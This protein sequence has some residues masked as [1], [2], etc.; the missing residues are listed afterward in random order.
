MHPVT[1]QRGDATLL[2]HMLCL[3]NSDM[4]FPYGH[5]KQAVCVL[6]LSA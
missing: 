6:G 1:L 2:N 3:A 5:Y 4:A